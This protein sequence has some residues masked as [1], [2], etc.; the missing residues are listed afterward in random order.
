MTP[1]RI[2]RAIIRDTLALIGRRIDRRVCAWTE[3][4]GEDDQ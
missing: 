4:T 3:T 1:A 2:L